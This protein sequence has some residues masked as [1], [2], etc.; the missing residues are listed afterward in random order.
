MTV[1][2]SLYSGENKLARD[3]ILLL[4]VKCILFREN[5]I[6]IKKKRNK[7]RLQHILHRHVTH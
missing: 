3:T 2:D 1:S 7:S 5:N 6:P 4:T